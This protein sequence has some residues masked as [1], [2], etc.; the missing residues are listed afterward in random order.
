MNLHHSGLFHRAIAQSGSAHNNWA[1]EHDPAT[2]G[3]EYASRLN[4]E[5]DDES[6]LGCLRSVD[7][8]QLGTTE[9]LMMVL[10]NFI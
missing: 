6:I 9:H 4:C 1:F 7:P 8:R 3:R 10:I 2:V 5:G